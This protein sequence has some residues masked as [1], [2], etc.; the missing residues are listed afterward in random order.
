MISISLEA[1]PNE[2]PRIIACVENEPSCDRL[3]AQ[4]VSAFGFH[5]TENVIWV[6]PAV[7][8]DSRDQRANHGAQHFGR[9]DI[10]HA[11]SFLSAPDN[12]SPNDRPAKVCRW[13]FEFSGDQRLPLLNRSIGSPAD[14]EGSSC[15]GQ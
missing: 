1:L 3:V 14:A 15:K 11:S 12:V 10:G 2:M 9:S 6:G 7:G 8:R 13:G 5:V 4:P